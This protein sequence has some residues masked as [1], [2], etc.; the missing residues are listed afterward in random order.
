MVP[1]KETVFWAGRFCLG[2]VLS[3]NTRSIVI[4]IFYCFF[5]D[6]W[7]LFDVRLSAC[8]TATGVAATSVLIINLNLWLKYSLIYLFMLKLDAQP[9]AHY[10]KKSTAGHSQLHFYYDKFIHLFF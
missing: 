4:D 8:S 10:D 5:H 7:N 3:A 2:A 1:K 9:C 6:L